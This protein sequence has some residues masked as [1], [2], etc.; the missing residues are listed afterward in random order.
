MAV[1]DG[2][3]LHVE[4]CGAPDGLPVLFLH[5]GPG[6]GCT[7]EQRRLFDPTRFRAILVDQRGA[8]H[9][10]PLGDISA[11][12][13][14]DLVLDLEYVREALGIATWIVFGSR[15]GSLLALSYARLYPERVRG[16]VLA[17]V[18][19][20]Q[21]GELTASDGELWR[22]CAAGILGSDPVVAALC[23]RSWLD[24]ERTLAGLPPLAS[25]PDAAQLAA[26]RVRAHYLAHDCF[27]GAGQLLAGIETLRHLPIVIVQGMAD[28]LQSAASAELLHRALP[29]ATW[30]PVAGA[31]NHA[32]NPAMARACIKALGWA[33]D[34]LTTWG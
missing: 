23:A 9:S 12:T 2:H 5:G 14:P 32:L 27:L 6:D 22:R 31:D 29:E 21:P 1:G 17:G 15:W 26:L 10:T 19:L 11:N 30:M 24:H 8:G 33:A 16:L 28:P 4:E 7:P 18:V 34:C 20:G 13:T 3:S 25:A